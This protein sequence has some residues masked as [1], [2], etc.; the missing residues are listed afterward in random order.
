MGYLDEIAK[1]RAERREKSSRSHDEYLATLGNDETS[2]D[3]LRL[4]IK[5]A[6]LPIFFFWVAYVGYIHLSKELIGVVPDEHV[7]WLAMGIPIVFQFIKAYC[8]TKCLRAWHFKW[9]DESAHDFWIYTLLGVLTIL[10]FVWTLKISFWDVKET[11]NNNFIEQNTITLGAHLKAATADIDA[12]IAKLETKEQSAGSLRT[13]KG[14]IN[15]AVQPIAAENAKSKSSLDAQRKTI[16]DAATME[17]STHSATVEKQAKSR[18]N[19]FQRFGGFGEFVEIICFV[20]IGLLEAK[21][22]RLNAEK[23]K[24]ASPTPST[25]GVHYNGHKSTPTSYPP[26]QNSGRVIFFNR[27]EDTGEVRSSGPTHEKPVPQSPQSVPQSAAGPGSIGADHILELLRQQLQ[28]EVANFRNPQAIPKTVAGRIH[29]HLSDAY[30]AMKSPDFVP[31]RAVG[32]KVYAYLVETVFKTLNEKGWPFEQ[33]RSMCY[34]ML[35]VIPKEHQVT[36]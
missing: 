13:K 18:G 33:D 35:D 31:S 25:N 15:W 9:Y 23:E 19:F 12:Q 3:E 1:K 7:M 24:Q 17:F 4:A 11:A 27:A 32:A 8:A 10:A 2:A 20:L 30:E 5:W 21:L 26:I 28:R 16:V 36:T 22:H 34:R 29:G 6:V 14:G